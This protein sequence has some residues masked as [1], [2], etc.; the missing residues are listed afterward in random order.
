MYS[1]PLIKEFYLI[2]RPNYV[3]F[4]T[5][6][7]T[8]GPFLEPGASICFQFLKIIA[9]SYFSLKN[10]Q[11]FNFSPKNFIALGESVA[12][13]STASIFDFLALR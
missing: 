2:E 10:L 3:G 1:D 13:Y 9:G 7:Q 12:G 5:N 4:I 11:V 8:E 6:S